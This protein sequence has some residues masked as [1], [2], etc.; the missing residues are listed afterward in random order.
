MLALCEAEQKMTNKGEKVRKEQCGIEADGWTCGL[1][2]VILQ[3]FIAQSS[4]AVYK[5]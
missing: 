1:S 5:A 3:S 2:T 4:S